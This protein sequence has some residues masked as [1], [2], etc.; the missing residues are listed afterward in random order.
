MRFTRFLPSTLVLALLMSPSTASSQG[1]GGGHGGH[2]G[3]GHGFHGGRSRAFG[4]RGFGHHFHGAALFISPFDPFGFGP[5]PFSTGTPAGAF[6][7]EDELGVP[8]ACSFVPPGI[9]LGLLQTGPALTEQPIVATGEIDPTRAHWREPDP[10]DCPPD[11]KLLR[12]PGQRQWRCADPR[13]QR[14]DAFKFA[15]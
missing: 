4:F 3:G 9:G 10:G 8:G 13:L 7:C 6:G 5:E 2:M 15:P 1:H 14:A 12:L 11:Q